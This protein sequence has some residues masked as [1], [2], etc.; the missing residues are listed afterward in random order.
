MDFA[1]SESSISYLNRLKLFMDEHV[2]PNETRY[3]QEIAK[4]DR[5]EPLELIEDLEIAS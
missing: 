1:F 4:G 5:W 3:L 2:H